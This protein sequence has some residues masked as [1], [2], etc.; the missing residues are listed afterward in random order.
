MTSET[1]NSTVTSQETTTLPGIETTHEATSTYQITTESVISET[2]EPDLLSTKETL[3]HSSLYGT[4]NGNAN[5]S[6][7][8]VYDNTLKRHYYVVD[9][10]V[11]SYDPATDSSDY[12]FSSLD[13]DKIISLSLSENYIY[14][15]STKDNYVYKYSFE[16]QIVTVFDERETYYINRYYNYLYMDKYLEDYDRRGL[17]LYYIQN[18][19]YSSQEAWYTATINLSGS[20]LYFTENN[21]Q[22]IKVMSNSFS[23]K[24]TLVDFSENNNIDFIE[25]L[26]LMSDDGI[27]QEFAFIAHNETRR[28]LFIYHTQDGL[29]QLMDIPIETNLSSLNTNG[30]VLYYVYDYS[31]YAYDLM[32]STTDKIIDFDFDVRNVN[33]VN[34]WIYVSNIVENKYYRIN[35]DTFQMINLFDD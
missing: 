15:I 4:S 8:A 2:E 24:Y 14:F 32:D 11:Y 10:Q 19:N 21:G 16:E 33:I 13:G 30:E 35:P 28:Y 18:Q 6:G 34:Y 17:Y 25:E 1:S 23:G 20:K 31:L 7:L 9:D 3:L 26:L 5:N 12:L 27:N 22:L 29:S